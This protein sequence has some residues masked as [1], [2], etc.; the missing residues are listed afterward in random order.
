MSR[1][2]GSMMRPVGVA[3]SIL[4]MPALVSACHSD[5]GWS[6][7]L[8]APDFELFRSQAYPVLMSD[9]AF[10]ECHGS[11]RRFF[12]VYGPGRTRLLSTTKID[13]PVTVSELQ[14]SFEHARSMLASNGDTSVMTSLLLRKPL[15]AAAGGV[16]HRGVDDYGRNV[17]ATP[18]A[19][20]YQALSRW[21]L[22]MVVAPVAGQAG[23]SPSAGSTG[24][25]P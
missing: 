20:G 13:G 19:A 21:A 14:V 3:L 1:R 9:C 17:Y 2:R 4:F 11:P 18:E 12:Q 5:P 7:Q 10:S 25:A 15:A 16:G 6:G 24:G 8:P 22:G 23:S